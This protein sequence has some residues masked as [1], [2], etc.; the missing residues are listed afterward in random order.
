MQL[1]GILQSKFDNEEPKRAQ[2]QSEFENAEPKI[3][4]ISQRMANALQSNAAWKT[5]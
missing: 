1:I 5:T 4:M 2:H 3:H